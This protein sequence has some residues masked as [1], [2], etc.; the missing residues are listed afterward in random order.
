M[1][2]FEKKVMLTPKEYEFLKK[3]RYAAAENAVQI[4]YYYD[5]D[6]FELN[7]KE[8]TCRIREKNG[9]CTATVKEHRL[10]GGDCSVENSN[11]VKDRYDDSI[12][13]EMGLCCQGS[14]ETFRSTYTPV[15]GLKIMLDRSAYLGTV[16]YELEIEYEK[17][18]GDA[19]NEEFKQIIAQMLEGKILMNADAFRTRIGHSKNKSARFFSRKA[20]IIRRTGGGIY[21]FYSK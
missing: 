18:C 10:K 3:Y 17:A 1:L 9:I 2:E 15:S 19:V 5:T 6:D 4:N 21:A 14:L 12:F 16:D 20:E 8:I 11:A 7:R 13:R